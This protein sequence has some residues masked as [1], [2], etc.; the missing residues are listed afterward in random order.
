[1][2]TK[3]LTDSELTQFTAD[4][5]AAA[6]D[7]L[8]DALD[9]V[10]RGKQRGRRTVRLMMPRGYMPKAL[11]SLSTDEADQVE[12]RLRSRGWNDKQVRDEL[13]DRLK[14]LDGQKTHIQVPAF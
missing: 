9:Q 5:R 13:R 7:D 8:I 10:V 11:R 6:L 3:P 14:H 4:V 12:S 2:T 1:M